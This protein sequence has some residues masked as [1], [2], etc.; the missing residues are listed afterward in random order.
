MGTLRM[1][2]VAGVAGVILHAVVV[3]VMLPVMFLAIDMTALHILGVLDTRTLPFRNLAIG[4]GPRFHVIDM[5]LAFF[6]THGFALRQRPRLHPLVDAPLLIGLALVDARG[7][8]LRHG[9]QGKGGKDSDGKGR[10]VFHLR[11]L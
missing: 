3:E 4:F 2:G 5:R 10:C 11:L 9:R 1:T 6:Q 8:G 7:A